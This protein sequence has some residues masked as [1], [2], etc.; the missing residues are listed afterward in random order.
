[1]NNFRP[2]V[3]LLALTLAL[4]PWVAQAADADNH[5]QSL[6]ATETML[7]V[8]PFELVQLGV[9]EGE[10]RVAISVDKEG[11]IDDCIPIAYTHPEFARVTVSAL[12]KWRF[13]PA[14]YNGQPIAAATEVGVKFAVEGTVVVS[15]TTL[16]SINLRLYS[17][18]NNT[19]DAYRPRTL[20]ELDRIPTPISAPSPGFPERLAKSGATG[21]VTVSFYIDESGAVRLPSV[22]ASEDPEL[23]AI[24]IDALRNWKFEPPTCKGR[25]VLVRASQ[26][27]SFRAPAAKQTAATN[28]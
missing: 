6:R 26:L 8:Y 7:P 21:Q 1:M 22:D 25:P 16:E 20:S 9:R 12:K 10:V 2:A 24:A 18:F 19:P 23:A 4:T 5:V 17:L 13:E 28:G 3:S 14:R 11:R 27:F 15:L